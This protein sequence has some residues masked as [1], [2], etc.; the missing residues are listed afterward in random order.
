MNQDSQLDRRSR[1]G[2]PYAL[3]I[4]AAFFFFLPFAFRAARLSLGQKQND[5]KDWLPGDF[6]ETAE[7]DWFAK[8]FASESFVLATWQGC[9]ADDQRLKLFEQKLL[10]ECEDYDPSGPLS[11]EL[12][13]QY[14]RARE[15]GEE[16]QLLHPGDDF[17]NW[18]GLQ[19]K[20]LQSASGQ[21]Y[22]VTPDGHLFRWEGGTSGPAA[23][24]RSMQK[25]F[26][27][28]ELDGQFVTAFG[29]EPQ[30]RIANPF[31]NDTS[32]LCASLFR[33]VQTGESILKEL[34]VEGGPLWPVDL[35]E[36]ERRPVVAR[37]RAMQRLTGTLFAPAV[38][39]DFAWT[40]EAFCER[41]PESAVERLPDDHALLV[42]DALSRIV[43]D[44]FDG[45][46][47]T[48]KSASL[49]ERTDVYYAVY[50]A[51]E[52]E[53]P[54]RLT[55]V[56]VT[57]TQL[58]K[59]HLPYALGRG[60]LGQP[61]GRLLQLAEQSGVRAAP[62]PSMAPPPFNRDPPDAIAGM[63]ALR[64]GGPP[65][66]NMAIDEEGS[67]TLIRLIG[68]SVV[69]GIVLSLICFGSLKITGMVFIVGGSSAILCMSVVWWTSGRVDAI[70]MSMPSLVYVLGLSGAIHVVNYYRDEVRKRGEAGA[71]RRALRHAFLPCTL[72][73]VTTAIGLASLFTS[74][75][76]PINN[77]GLYAAIGVIMTLGVLFSYLPAALQTFPP[78][79]A[80]FREIPAESNRESQLS[81][82]WASAGRWV[83]RHHAV[84][85]IVCILVLVGCGTGLVKIETSVQ[86]LRLFDEDSRIIRDYAWLEE[87]FGKLVP[88]ELIVRVPPSI[89]SEFAD[90]NQDESE[91]S[92]HEPLDILERVEAVAR[93]RTV[94]HRTL[95][96]PGR[97]IVGQA[98]GADTFLP[99]L[100][101]P[102][103]GYNPV[104]TKAVRELAAASDQLRNNDYLRLEQSGQF[105]GSELWRI[106]LR[107]AALS[108]VDY[109]QFISTLRESVEPV[110]RAYET[111]EQLLL[112]LKSTKQPRVLVV[113]SPR[114]KSLAQAALTVSDETIDR[115]QTYIATLGELLSGERMESPSW[116]D[117]EPEK[118]K[119]L[120]ASDQWER[121]VQRFDAIVWLGSDDFQPSDFAA[122]EIFIDGQK[123]LSKSITPTIMPDGVPV[124]A[125][126]G[127]LQVIYTGVV[128]VVYKAQRTLLS[129]L[130]D[131]IELAFVL[132]A[133]VMIWLLNP[134][135]L[136][137][138]WL[139]PRHLG[140]GIAAGAVAMVPNVF[141]VILV[142]GIMCH[143]GLEI[144]IGTMMTAS[145][146]MGVAVDDT[147]HFLAW[148]RENLDRGM[149]RVEAVIET[150]RRVGPA[151]TQTT[152]V[153]GLGLFVFSLSTFTPTQRFGTL[154]LV[155]LA[156]ALVG[157]LIL[158][159]ALLAGPAGKLFKPR[160][161]PA[162]AEGLDL[163]EENEDQEESNLEVASSP[164]RVHTPTQRS[165]PP[166]RLKG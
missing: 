120:L 74:N 115:R 35:T 127:P 64:M 51:A 87:N 98:M 59:D 62:P 92:S 83:T 79:K 26:G 23:G 29:K 50:D 151:M 63:P 84:V 73:S 125:D 67:I 61:R 68:Y 5:V 71:A 162:L 118:A 148:F 91:S 122:A 103:N 66:D 53:P 60:V 153:G 39:D 114:P 76:A 95:G 112:Q 82:W 14:K 137:L 3:L 105:E 128:P 48:L 31:Y 15:F 110:L 12:A 47:E 24:Y 28:F 11:P 38:T 77:F 107:V 80:F 90:A 78:S 164:L 1:R 101:P 142:F 70:L 123:T 156:A 131:S 2:I 13:T 32:L 43:E 75:L 129:S 40:S 134:G 55:C 139:R 130:A 106:S 119:E 45:S 143:M 37:R 81:Q 86:L 8:H 140:F 121:F 113:G 124:V 54:P 72:A 41:I 16:L 132:I 88:M 104:R 163:I 89:Q 111:R 46:I 93:I 20:W 17:L 4:L 108:D 146:A 22:Y 65:V 152:V 157:D 126:A 147:I 49:A 150:Y 25:K 19:E 7:L 102:S 109:G 159:P 57:L 42:Q 34:T 144:D 133:A 52:I 27:T 154:M 136:P 135:E 166:H 158:L 141:P 58:G 85:S 36:Q 56:L 94:V 160:Q 6:P 96:E 44:R 155:M 116:L 33:S 21:W 30:G 9:T 99:P 138:S 97:G 10:R 100:P 145:V 161:R 69:I 117:V 165:D 149:H 18:G